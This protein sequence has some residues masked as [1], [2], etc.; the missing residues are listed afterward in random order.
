MPRRR[1]RASRR[2][3]QVLNPAWTWSWW[4]WS[5]KY[6]LPLSRYGPPTLYEPS[7]ATAVM[8][9]VTSERGVDAAT[10][11]MPLMRQVSNARPRGWSL[12]RVVPN[13][14]VGWPDR[15]TLTP[16]VYV[17][18]RPNMARSTVSWTWPEAMSA[19]EAGGRSMRD[20][21]STCVASES[22]AAAAPGALGLIA[23]TRQ[24]GTAADRRTSNVQPRWVTA[25]DWL[26]TH[27]RV[28]ISTL[29]DEAS[30]PPYCASI[31]WTFAGSGAGA[32]AWLAAAAVVAGTE[33]LGAEAADVL[34]EGDVTVADVLGEP[35]GAAQP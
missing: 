11:G 15:I 34:G 30:N 4:V 17:C 12:R 18:A 9:P 1:F 8:Y 25:P 13:T 33:A 27:C 32:G 31:T 5:E 23:V 10:T 20:E 2:R 24:E 19:R 3:P 28:G 14:Y 7:A 26:I 22:T 29:A 6:T 16:I 35:L 21:L